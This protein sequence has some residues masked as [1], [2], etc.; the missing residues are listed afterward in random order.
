MAHDKRSDQGNNLN[1][2]HETPA[3]SADHKQR[4]QET[5]EEQARTG[6]DHDDQGHTPKI[7][8][9]KPGR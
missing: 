2:P 7:P 5:R 8:S 3:D 9:V 1:D 6:E 4:T